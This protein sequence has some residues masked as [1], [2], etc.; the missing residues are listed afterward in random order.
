MGFLMPRV[1]GLDKFNRRMKRLPKDVAM[2]VAPAL[3]K[4]AEEVADM[5]RALAPHDEGDLRDAITVTA[6]N[7]TTPS[8]IA[9][10]GLGV[11]PGMTAKEHEA[12][13]TY[14]KGRTNYA[15]HV[16]TGTSD[17]DAQPY[18]GPGHRL[19]RKR[20]LNRIKRELTKAVKASFNR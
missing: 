13:V 14:D 18:I 16:E 4:S 10:D 19:A 9:S 2:A 1:E 20:A 12:L 17:T 5:Q 6:P 3:V 7:G 11:I 8:V 15:L